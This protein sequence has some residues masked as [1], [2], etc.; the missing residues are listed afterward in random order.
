MFDKAKKEVKKL[1]DK[2]NC[3]TGSEKLKSYN[4][5]MTKKDFII[6]SRLQ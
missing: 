5:R 3:L 4:N 6:Q 2:Y 1:I